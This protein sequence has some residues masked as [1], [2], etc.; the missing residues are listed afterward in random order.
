VWCVL[1]TNSAVAAGALLIIIAIPLRSPPMVTAG[2]LV[3]GTVSSCYALLFV[4]HAGTV[5]M[6]MRANK[7]G[8]RVQL[9]R[10]AL[11]LALFTAAWGGSAITWCDAA[12]TGWVAAIVLAPLYAV[13]CRFRGTKCVARS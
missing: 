12:L 11:L 13:L 3:V 6:A 10:L 4:V 5:M 2:T 8:D 1:I 9:R 7:F